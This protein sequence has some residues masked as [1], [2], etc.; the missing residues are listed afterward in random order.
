[1]VKR[2]SIIKLVPKPKPLFEGKSPTVYFREFR[3]K[4]ARAHG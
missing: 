3:I 1:M 2:K 4:I